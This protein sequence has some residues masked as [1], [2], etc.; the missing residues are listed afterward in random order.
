[1]QLEPALSFNPASR[2]SMSG[3]TLEQR[4]NFFID[5]ESWF[6]WFNHTLPGDKHAPLSFNINT[7]LKV[8]LGRQ[9]SKVLNRSNQHIYHFKEIAKAYNLP[10]QRLSTTNLILRKISKWRERNR[11]PKPS[12]ES[13]KKTIRRQKTGIGFQKA[14][15]HILQAKAERSQAEIAEREIMHLK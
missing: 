11:M 2:T 3:T 12:I 5:S 9:T 15:T 13:Q 10:C 1:M 6:V 14:S 8:N 4:L 7:T